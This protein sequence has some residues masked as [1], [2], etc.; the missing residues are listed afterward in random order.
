MA[1]NSRRSDCPIHCSL[2]LLGDRWALI[3]VR[4]LL[5]H[6]G[7]TFGELLDSP[8]RIATNTLS[9]RLVSLTAAGIVE[10]LPGDKRYLLTEKGLDLAPVLIELTLWG[11]RHE[12]DV[13]APQVD[14]D[15]YHKHP[16]Q[17]I[18]YIKIAARKRR[19][20]G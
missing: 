3:I 14:L 4:D 2:N 12:P 20:K 13:K 5:V 10:Q 19:N 16:Q 1:K 11:L 9:S 8:E 6:S 7:A 15:Q 17:F 18:K